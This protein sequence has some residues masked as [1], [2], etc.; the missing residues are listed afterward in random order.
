MSD[1][2][3]TADVDTPAAAA[4]QQQGATDPA[5]GEAAAMAAAEGEHSLMEDVRKQ[6]AVM[7][8]MN[9]ND[10]IERQELKAAM[11]EIKD[12]QHELGRLISD[13]SKDLSLDKAELKAYMTLA[14]NTENKV[15]KLEDG[16]ERLTIDLHDCCNRVTGLEKANADRI[17]FNRWA[18]PTFITILTALVAIMTFV[19]VQVLPRLEVSK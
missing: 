4:R 17:A 6:L 19:L 14:T 9:K 12:G 8:A 2:F 10:A 11:R 7:E 18:I 16:K 15:S 13:L 5:G 1:G 3:I